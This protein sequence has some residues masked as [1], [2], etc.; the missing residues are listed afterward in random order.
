MKIWDKVVKAVVD[1]MLLKI[2]D[3]NKTTRGVVARDMFVGSMVATVV[4]EVL[5]FN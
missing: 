3:D 1:E 5:T 2:L 4:D